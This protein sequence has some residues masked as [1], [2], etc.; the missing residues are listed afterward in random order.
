MRQS[1]RGNA[2]VL[3]LIGV[4]LFGAL[5]MTFMRGSKQGQGN[6]S[7]QQTKLAAQEMMDYST[8]IRNAIHK[9]LQKGCSENELNFYNTTYIF[10]NNN[11]ASVNNPNAPSDKS[12]NVFDEAGGKIQPYL[13][14]PNYQGDTGGGSLASISL[15]QVD[16]KGVGT[17]ANDIIVIIPHIKRDICLAIN[18]SLGIPLVT[19]DVPPYTAVTWPAQFY[20][21]I[22]ASTQVGYDTSSSVVSG[23]QGFCIATGSAPSNLW[24]H[25]YYTV[26]LE[27]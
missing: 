7:K 11:I 16:I 22:V 8:Q 1:E 19:G 23:K 20:G 15:M 13:L 12:C 9:L 21:T 26:V 18:E 2:I 3:I 14:S 27:R 4:A 17:T 24:G 10:M 25:M 5:A 6:L